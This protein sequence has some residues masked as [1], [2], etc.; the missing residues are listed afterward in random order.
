MQIKKC[1]LYITRISTRPVHT[2]TYVVNP[3]TQG[4]MSRGR[5]SR[6]PTFEILLIPPNLHKGFDTSVKYK[7]E[8][9][10]KELSTIQ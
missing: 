9:R 4:L 10:G 2:D 3:Y 6:P 1:L 8:K 7:Y 5:N